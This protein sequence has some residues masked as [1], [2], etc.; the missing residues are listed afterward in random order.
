M[1]V[2]LAK[3]ADGSYAM[4]MVDPEDFEWANRWRWHWVYDKRKKKQYARR[5]TSAP[6]GPNGERRQRQVWLHK[7][8][9]KRSGKKRRTRRH[10]IADHLNG[11]S[12]DCRRD[13]L[14]WATHA[15]NGRNKHGR[16]SWRANRKRDRAAGKCGDG[17]ADPAV[18][19]LD[20]SAGAPA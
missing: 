9:L 7:E 1:D 3:G 2:V 17:G 10:T 13:N 19:R 5:T 4:V 6:R 11:D 18:L 12:L 8:V 16:E 14:R 20:A 15:M